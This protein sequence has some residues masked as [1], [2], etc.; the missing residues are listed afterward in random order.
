MTATEEL[1]LA[2][3]PA[4]LEEPPGFWP[5]EPSH[6]RLDRLAARV[7]P[8]G[9]V[10]FAVVVLSAGIVFWQLEP[11][12][13]FLNTTPAGGDMGAHVWLP[14]F[15]KR[16]LLPRLRLTGWTPDYY[17]GFPALTF[18]FPLPIVA[19]ALLSYVIHYSIAFKLVVCAGLVT[20]PLSVYSFARSIRMR[21]P[22]PAV[23]AAATL[24]YIFC[25]EFTIYGGNI[26]ST[27]AGEFCFAISLS[28]AFLFLGRLAR[29]LEDGRHRVS[30]SL[31]LAA[32]GLSHVLPL[33]FALVG[34]GVLIVMRLVTSRDWRRLK[35]AIP[36]L[37]TGG[38][39]IGFWALP[40]VWRLPYATNM[41]YGKLTDYWSQLSHKDDLLIGL[42][43]G[44]FV[45]AISRF[46]FLGVWLGI[47]AIASA[48][49]FVI[50][51]ASRLWNARL[52]PFWFLCL[53]LLVGVLVY[54][55]ASIVI[56][57]ACPSADQAPRATMATAVTPVLALVGFAAFVLYPL[58][59]SAGGSVDYFGLSVRDP[60]FVKAWTYWNFSGYQNPAKSREQEYFALVD[61][62][63]QVGQRYGCGQALWEYEPSLN[64]MGT[65][66]AL[67]LLPYW[68]S[69]CI[70]SEEGLYYESSAT[71]PFHFLNVA[72]TSDHPPDPVGG[73]DYPTSLNIPEAAQ[74]MRIMGDRYFMADSPDVE[75]QANSD[76]ADL[77]LIATVGPFSFDDTDVSGASS[78]VTRTWDIYEVT[79]WSL[80]TPLANQPVVMEG[81]QSRDP[82]VWLKAAEAWYLDS[83]RWNVFET[84]SGPAN[85]ARVAADDPNPPVTPEPYAQVTDVVHHPESISFDVDQTGVPV[86]I[87]ES[88]FPNW[89]V[90]GASG[91]Y[92]VTP[93]LMVVVP[94]AHHVELYYGYTPVDWIGLGMSGLGLITL[95][96][97][98]RAGPVAFAADR[99]RRRRLAWTLVDAD[100]DPAAAAPAWGVGGGG[101]DRDKVPARMPSAPAAHLDRVF[102]AYDIRGTVPDQLDAELSRAVGAAFAR[103]SAANRV[104]V[105]RDMR[106]SG[107]ELAAAFAEGVMAMGADV[108]DLGLCST[109]ELYFAS[110]WL[111]AP[112]AMFTASHNPAGYNGIKLCR[113]GARP[114]GVETGLD[115]IR[116]GAADWLAG[117]MPVPGPRGSTVRLDVL[118]QYA[119]KVRSFVDPGR[120]AP[121]KVVADTANGMGGLVVPAVFEGLPIDLEI[122]FGELDGT[123]PNHPADPIQPENLRALQA[124]IRETGADV[125]LAFD[126]DADRCFLVDD[127]GVPLPGSTTTALVAAALLEKTPGS[128]IL[129]NLICSKAVPEII[130][131]RGGTPVRTRVGHSYIKAVMADT[132]ALF[133]GE[134]SGHYYFRDNYRADSGAIAALVV[135]EALSRAGRPLSEVRRD[136]ER[137][138]ASG[139]INTEVADPA[140]V[141]EAVAAHYGAAGARLD[142]LDGLTVDLGDW[143]FNLRPSNTEPLL[144]LNLEAADPAACEAH[145]AEVRSLI[146]AVPERSQP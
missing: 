48:I 44:A 132:G 104:L 105:A 36:V 142:R 89:Q 96:W 59:R 91:V 117:R 127:L 138:A 10:T 84:A 115:Q 112:G 72:E 54:E 30:A 107:V 57:L 101:Q 64:E 47:M 27:M 133:G 22:A 33:L 17:D 12:Q 29:G 100:G 39:L 67:M 20:L 49:G 140:A 16:V 55:V 124:R 18:Y 68:T 90:K 37:A 119:A 1:E 19:I 76:P 75:A 137:Y 129:Y 70:G 93:N 125:G 63:A 26:A 8:E 40:F 130:R 139:E 74:Q 78:E 73:L 144:R 41:H 108:V 134:H 135:L 21:F 66:D 145:T 92:R 116:A 131:E 52:L 5:P 65:P 42:A 53:Y 110:G 24:P 51:P 50:M 94:T 82:E 25:R 23:M 136:F 11:S 98:W 146:G 38:L 99:R 14:A 15:V 143:W 86:L 43:A 126:G 60:S 45:V 80:V 35:V 102:K 46:N 97:F 69:G 113:S 2:L 61:K 6:P 85:W 7:T 28:F 121:L 128:T 111:D 4:G 123:F 103:F 106:P 62:M 95:V 3:P 71:T 83:N 32:C 141:I 79:G 56:E 81:V 34:A 87:R 88:Y 77:Q 13:I 31:L 109:D 58:P 120:L 114:V 118:A 122:L 9:L